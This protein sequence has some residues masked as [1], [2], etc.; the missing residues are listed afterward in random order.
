MK[1]G[2]GE[3]VGNER[4]ALGDTC[5]GAFESPSPPRE[6]DGVLMLAE[7]EDLENVNLGGEKLILTMEVKMVSILW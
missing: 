7:D 2:G 5:P 4:G 1:I 3:V 6:D